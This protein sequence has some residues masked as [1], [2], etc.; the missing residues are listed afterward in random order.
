MGCS[1]AE[2]LQDAPG[3]PFAV[4]HSVHHFASAADAVAP[5]E[6]LGI[7]GLARLRRDDD[8]LILQLHAP[9]LFQE[10]DQTRLPKRGDHHV[11]RQAE[12]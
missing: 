6:V 11:G 5:G 3:G 12:V 10:R 2:R 1:G 9:A 4:G 7:S 8:A